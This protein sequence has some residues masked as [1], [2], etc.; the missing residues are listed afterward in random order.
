MKIIVSCSPITVLKEKTNQKIF[1]FKKLN[2]E[3]SE[4]NLL[5]LIII[6]VYK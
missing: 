2:S 3:F 1:T 4:Q 6:V 5:K